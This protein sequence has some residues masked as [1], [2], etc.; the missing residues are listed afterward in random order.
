M[1]GPQQRLQDLDNVGYHQL[2]LRL[3]RP[4][5][6]QITKLGIETSKSRSLVI[7]ELLELGLTATKDGQKDNSSA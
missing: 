4:L 5:Y 3:L 2:C 1:F 6:H 7:H